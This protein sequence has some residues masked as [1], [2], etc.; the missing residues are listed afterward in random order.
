[1]RQFLGLTNYYRKFIAYY[2]RE[3]KALSTLLRKDITFYWKEPQQQAALKHLIQ[4]LTQAPL[5]KY[6]DFSKPF[7]VTC[8]ASCFAIGAVLNQIYKLETKN[9]DLPVA[10]FS[11]HLKN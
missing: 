11:R 5:L 2:A 3:T 1:M 8:D 10:Y 4:A 6:P 9:H 7:I